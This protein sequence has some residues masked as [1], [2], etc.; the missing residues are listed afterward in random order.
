MLGGIHANSKM[1]ECTHFCSTESSKYYLNT[2]W[3]GEGDSIYSKSARLAGHSML[4]TRIS[5]YSVLQYN[6]GEC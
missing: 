6:D 5:L 3:N 2:Q 1:V 4:L